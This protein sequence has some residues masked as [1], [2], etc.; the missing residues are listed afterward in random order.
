MKTRLCR[1]KGLSF[2]WNVKLQYHQNADVRDTRDTLEF[3][4]PTSVSHAN[5]TI[6]KKASSSYLFDPPEMTH[7]QD[8]DSLRWCVG[9]SPWTGR[10]RMVL[11]PVCLANQQY[12]VI[13]VSSTRVS[14]HGCS[15]NTCDS[16]HGKSGD[17]RLP[18]VVSSSSVEIIDET[19]PNGKGP[20]LL[21]K[22]YFLRPATDCRKFWKPRGCPRFASTQRGQSCVAC[23]PGGHGGG[24]VGAWCCV[25]ATWSTKAKAKDTT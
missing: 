16:F 9:T 19:W 7:G 15:Q 11:M 3:H 25:G 13:R 4:P 18:A 12:L 17:P 5:G 8:K 1:K 2:D 10:I 6:K 14:R 24:M 23:E 20:G 21:A 22:G